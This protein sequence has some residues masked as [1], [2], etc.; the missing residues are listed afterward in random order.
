MG[1]GGGGMKKEKCHRFLRL[2]QVNAQ[3]CLACA[4]T[5]WHGY[6]MIGNQRGRKSTGVVGGGLSVRLFSLIKLH[7]SS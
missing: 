1:G 7:H 6:S 3:T 4:K 5:A 2:R